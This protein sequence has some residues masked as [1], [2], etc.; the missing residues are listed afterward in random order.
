MLSVS[1]ILSASLLIRLLRCCSRT[2]PMEMTRKTPTDQSSPTNVYSSSEMGVWSFLV[3]EIILED[4]ILRRLRN[5][6]ENKQN[7]L[8]NRVIYKYYIFCFFLPKDW[9]KPYIQTNSRDML[10]PPIVKYSNKEYR[11]CPDGKMKQWRHISWLF[12]SQ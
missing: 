9:W 6:I 5:V 12:T 10:F 2:T 3:M 8:N 4:K 7:I 11:K 1:R